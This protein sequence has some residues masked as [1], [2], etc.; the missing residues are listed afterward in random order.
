MS[1]R[2]LGCTLVIG[3][4]DYTDDS[5]VTG[6]THSTETNGGFR[7]LSF[8]R[9][10]AVQDLGVGLGQKVVLYDTNYS[11][12]VF[13]GRVN[14]INPKSGRVSCT[15]ST[16]DQV[17]RFTTVTAQQWGQTYP[18]GRMAG[19]IYL[20][21][22][23][24]VQ[25]LRDALTLTPSVFDGGITDPGLQVIGQSVN[26]GG[27]T[28]EQIWN[29]V[30]GL[31]YS[32]TTPL[33]WHIRGANGVE[34][35]VISF[36]DLA[37]RYYVELQE[38]QIDETYS[39]ANIINRS[40]VP[41]GNNDVV[42]EPAEG[43]PISYA[44]IP[45]IRDYYAN[46]NN[47][48]N[49]VLDAQGLAGNLLTRF[50]GFRSINDTLT[51][52]CIE[53]PVRV[54]PPLVTT[55]D[56][57]WPLHL[58]EAGHGLQLMNRTAPYP[59]NPAIK[60]VTGTE[61]D[62]DTGTLTVRCGELGG[63]GQSINNIVDYN[64]NRLFF[65]PASS[66]PP[67]WINHPLADADAI[68]YV[69]PTLSQLGEMSPNKPGMGPGIPV[70]TQSMNGDLPF[71]KVIHPGLVADEGIEVNANIPIT[72]TGF[73]AAVKTTPGTF[74]N[75]EVLLIGELGL[76]ADILTATAWKVDT[77][78]AVTPLGLTITV[79]P[80]ASRQIGQIS[81]NIVLGRGIKI[82]WQV[83]VAA[84][85]DAYVAAIALKA[86]KAYPGLRL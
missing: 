18:S 20:D 68:T 73:Q 48:I 58:I 1:L 79:N 85:G 62:W 23:P 41:W 77:A 45:I 7:E 74:T 83:N 72:E 8:T 25:V 2:D 86:D 53:N 37:A 75:Y 16:T 13:V 10:C 80:A 15:R 35:V 14:E 44:A 50:S 42:Q 63:F 66:A 29:Y 71:E 56:D 4:V 5:R 43:Y 76:T 69:G 19:R 60:Y 52:K 47:N 55:P 28:A 57:N 64:V 17:V 27:Y 30:C 39:L 9:E 6:L 22:T 82:M 24:F 49:R 81:P 38:D 12:Y 26:I 59:Y 70:F 3:N 61:Y 32:L 84:V 54:V 33:Q 78:G 46:G 34:V 65:G 36:A 31:T 67:L 40:T 11:K 51:I 21:S